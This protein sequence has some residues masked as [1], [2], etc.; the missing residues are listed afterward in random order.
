M[1]QFYLAGGTAIALHLNHRI[2]ADLDL[3]SLRPNVDLEAIAGSIRAA[4]P[5]VEVISIGDVSVRLRVGEVP[6][7]IVRYPHPP[8]DAP[9]LLGK[10]F[11]VAGTYTRGGGVDQ[12]RAHS[13]VF[14]V[15]MLVRSQV[16]KRSVRRGAERIG[17]THLRGLSYGWSA[18][19]RTGW[20]RGSRRIA[21]EG[22]PSHGTGSTRRSAHAREGAS[23]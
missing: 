1:E 2:S 11:R 20:G 4:V 6:V 3:F 18:L 22:S 15:Q 14:I 21:H 9:K 16:V 7:D 13:R 19:A 12:G 23:Q 10:I 5:D 17:A 8:L